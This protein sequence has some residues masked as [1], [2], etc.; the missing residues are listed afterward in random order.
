M[1]ESTLPE[2]IRTALD[3]LRKSHSPDARADALHDNWVYVWLPSVHMDE[4][5]FP[6]PHE[7]GLWVRLPLQFPFALPHGIVTKDPLLATDGHAV[8]GH[9]PGHEMCNPVRE[10][11]GAHY[12]SWTWNGELGQGPTL[13]SADDILE[14][15]HWVERRIRL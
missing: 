9:N 4:E 15:V 11:G 3:I 10:I 7:R 14:V 12:Y 13:R 1:D 8:K 2:P 6:A 5:K